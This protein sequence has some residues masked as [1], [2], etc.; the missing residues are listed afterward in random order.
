MSTG[1]LWRTS[2]VS[3]EGAVDPVVVLRPVVV[4][5]EVVDFVVIAANDPAELM[6]SGGDPERSVIG[7]SLAAVPHTV[8]DSDV[9]PR[10]A[11]IMANGRPRRLEMTLCR[12]HERQWELTC[13]P[14]GDLM[15]VTVRDVTE[16]R[17]RARVRTEI[18]ALKRITA[19]R[20]RVARD[21]HDN[22]V[23]QVIGASMELARLA[24]WADDPVAGELE[25]VISIHDDI[26]RELR[27]ILFGLQRPSR[28]VRNEITA[29]VERSSGAL[30]FTPEVQLGCVD[31]LRG[32]Q[33]EAAHLL[34]TLRE[35]LS[36]IARHAQA[37]Q[38]WIEIDACDGQLS[39]TVDD[40]GC[41][42]A[43]HGRRGNGLANLDARAALLDGCC[44][45]TS[46]AGKGTRVHW[47]VPIR[48]AGSVDCTPR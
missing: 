26:V 45:V 39:M 32:N 46:R 18:E 20:K 42:I 1:E 14:C 41:G 30:G 24:T 19:E 2:Y 34:L 17:E 22:V 38:V 36:N 44:A 25:H 8:L 23:Q 12:D 10:G 21:L 3:A 5:N 16:R 31:A 48:T 9:I 47:S 40:N 33:L 6:L 27:E 43:D 11:E 4:D 29:I 15:M 37:T 28:D 7:I 35:V 13:L